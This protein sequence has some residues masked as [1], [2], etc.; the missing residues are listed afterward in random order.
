LLRE[1]TVGGSASGAL[2][3]EDFRVALVHWLQA[4]CW[5][6]GFFFFVLPLSVCLSLCVL[7]V[8]Q[9]KPAPAV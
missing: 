4:V 7:S 8:C 1:P 3:K 2:S 5:P 6:V 9:R